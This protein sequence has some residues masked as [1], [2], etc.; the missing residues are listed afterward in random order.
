[1]VVVEILPAPIE[2]IVG[3]VP[4]RWR[5]LGAGLRAQIA[6]S[7]ARVTVRGSKDALVGLRAGYH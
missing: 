5:N 6:P 1:M 3:D 4:V 7:I 2:R